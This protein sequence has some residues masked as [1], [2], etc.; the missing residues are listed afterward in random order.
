MTNKIIN[1]FGDD[2]MEID[3]STKTYPNKSILVDRDIYFDIDG[4]ATANGK[5][6]C[7]ITQDKVKRYLGR[8]IMGLTKVDKHQKVVHKDGLHVDYRKDNLTIVTGGEVDRSRQDKPLREYYL[9]YLRDSGLAAAYE[10]ARL[11]ENEK[12]MIRELERFELS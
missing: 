2:G 11:N 12:R 6:Y 5:R 10:D 1:D 7:I 3:I 9:S 4:K 8:V